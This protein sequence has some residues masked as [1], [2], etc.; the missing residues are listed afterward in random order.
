MSRLHTSHWGSHAPSQLISL[1]AATAA[2]SDTTLPTGA[3]T[4]H[5]DQC[6]IFVAIECDGVRRKPK[7]HRH[8]QKRSRYVFPQ[9]MSSFANLDSTTKLM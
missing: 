5:S 7:L 9:H 3:T 2:P 4:I 1:A 6:T 8:E